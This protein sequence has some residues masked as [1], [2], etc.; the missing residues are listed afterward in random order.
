MIH[1]HLRGKNPTEPDVRVE[2]YIQISRNMYVQPI[3]LDAQHP[4]SKELLPESPRFI[5]VN[6][7]CIRVSFR[8]GSVLSSNRNFND[9]RLFR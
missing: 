3:N 6:G 7:C 1:S 9:Q 5:S 2:Q 8:L 4:E